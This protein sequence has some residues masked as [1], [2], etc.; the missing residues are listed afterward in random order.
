MDRDDVSVRIAEREL[1]AEGAL[2]RFLHDGHAGLGEASVQPG[3][4]RV[5]EPDSDPRAQRRCIEIDTRERI[6]DGEGHSVAGGEDDRGWVRDGQ[7]LQPYE[8][9]VEASGRRGIA[10]L[11]R[12]ERRSCCGSHQVILLCYRHT[13]YV[14]SLTL[15]LRVC[16]TVDM[17]DSGQ[18]PERTVAEEL[19][20]LIKQTQAVLNQRM[21]EVLRP[22]GLSVAQHA[23]LQA[24]HDSPGIT[25]SELARRVF[26]SRQSMSVLLQG[27]EKRGLI[28]RTEEPGPRR[29]RG[30]TLTSDAVALAQKARAEV[31][32][33]A[34]AMTA[35]LG[36]REREQL[37][38][39]LTACRDSLTSNPS[40]R[41]R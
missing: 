33:I 36:T 19:G 13:I 35:A 9:F 31:G 20:V 23:C 24:L 12:D 30:M 5:V 28:D 10:N 32:Q 39:L 38:S 15:N 2:E 37:Q 25:G 1:E 4:I 41:R 18:R 16:Q 27:L 34:D 26:V 7:P 21:D 17:E 3:R 6:A 22:L 8:V 29:E 14:N 11:E 40:C